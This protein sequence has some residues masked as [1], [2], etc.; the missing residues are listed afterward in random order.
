VRARRGRSAMGNHLGIV[1]WV[2]VPNCSRIFFPYLCRVTKNRA[3]AH[4]WHNTCLAPVSP[5]G[6][7]ADALSTHSR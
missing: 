1:T 2:S 5:S 4:L 7:G 6:Y 3:I